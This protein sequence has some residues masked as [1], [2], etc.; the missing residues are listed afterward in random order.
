VRPRFRPAPTRL[1]LG[2][3][4]VRRAVVTAADIQTALA[5]QQRTGER[6]GAILVRMNLATSVDVAEALATQ[7][8]IAF[9]TLSQTAPDPLAVAVVPH[10][11]ARKHTCVAMSLDSNV[12]TVAGADPL[13]YDLVRDL[14]FCTGFKVRQVIATEA[15]I[16]DG[17]E[18]AYGRVGVQTHSGNG[19]RQ[20]I[21]G[22]SAPASPSVVAQHDTETAHDSHPVFEATTDTSDTADA[23]IVALVNEILAQAAAARASDIHIEPR[24]TDVTVRFRI[25]GLLAHTLDVPR[26]M[27]PSLVARLKLLAGLDTAEQ[28]RPQDGRISTKGAAGSAI[29]VRVSTLPTVLGEKIVLRLLQGGRSVPAID[30]LGLAAESLRDV[31]RL[32]QRQHG[33][34]LVVGP[35][36]SGKTTTLYSALGCVDADR[37]NI[38][39]IEDPVECQ[40]PGISQTQINPKLDVTFAKALRSILRQDPDVVMV[41]EIRDVE[42][43]RVAMQAAQTG[44]LVLSTLHTDDAPSCVTRLADM[45]IEPYITGSTLVGVIAQRLIRRLCPHCKTRHV[46]AAALVD[47]LHMTPLEASATTFYQAVGCDQCGHAG[48]HG[49]IGIYEVMVVTDQV[50]RCIAQQAGEMEVRATAYAAG[51][52]SLFQDGL[53]KVTAGVTSA[54]EL[55]R[56]VDDVPA[57]VAR[58]CIAPSKS[59]DRCGTALQ[60]AGKACPYCRSGSVAVP[61]NTALTAVSQV[62]PSWLSLPVAPVGRC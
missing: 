50:R 49:R 34:I 51:M 37:T 19:T 47:A 6:L 38:V 24:T 25:D 13:D 42:T 9:V 27:H 41:G 32:L 4:L 45:G 2:E 20:A 5:D 14:E 8:G 15:D 7:L 44:H 31:R 33:M 56:V 3:S 17:I 55:V 29:D 46:P 18:R 36:G 52:L 58:L 26:W 28:R 60:P 59:C 16:L 10:E 1:R 62:A 54:E 39:T 61:A 23:P 11:M 30:A 48:Y 57:P 53:R 43:A 40:R 12:L 21:T 22:K 35:T